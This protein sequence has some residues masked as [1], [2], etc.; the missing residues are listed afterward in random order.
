[1]LVEEGVTVEGVVGL[2]DGDVESGKAVEEAEADE[3]ASEESPEGA[4]G[5]CYW[6]EL[7]FI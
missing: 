5:G 3:V 2:I 4:E 7:F 6:G 1:M